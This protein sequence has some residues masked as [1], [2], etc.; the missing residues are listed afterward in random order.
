MPPPLSSAN[1]KPLRHER[2]VVLTPMMGGA[3][4]ISEMTRQWVRVL[5]SR[6]GRDVGG[7]EVWSLDDLQRPVVAAPATT[8]HTA[9]GRRIRFAAFALCHGVASAG[10]TL[11]IAMHLHLLPLA[12]PFLWR[13]ARL[14]PI[15]MGIEAWA[16]LRPIERA[17]MRRAWKVA[18]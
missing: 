10:E 8:F 15:L 13:G 12:L 11:V 2:V 9:R 3:D 7:L 16:P 6:V 5:E 18:A 17:A 1:T 4:G 14:L